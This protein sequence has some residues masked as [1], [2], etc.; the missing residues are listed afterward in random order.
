MAQING[1]FS[2]YSTSIFKPYIVWSITSQNQV[3]NTSTV[4]VNVYF[5]KY[6]ASY[7]AFNTGGFSM[8]ININ[9]STTSYTETFDL[10]SGSVPEIELI[11]TRTSTIT[12]NSDGT[13]SI[14][15][16][17]SGDTESIGT[18]NFGA[19][20][21]LT[22]IP[23]EATITNSPDFT[24]G[25][26]IPLT[27]SNPG[28]FYLKA[29]LYVNNTLISTDSIGQVT[30][31]TITPDSGEISAM[32]AQIT[33]ATSMSTNTFI[34]IQTFSDSG[35]T[36]QVGSNKDKAVTASINTT[37][38]VPTFTD[39]SVA[40][41]DKNVVVTDSYGNT[42]IT[43]S[44]STLLGSNTK[45]IK[46]YSKLRAT[47]SVAN[48]AVAQNSATM[49]KYKFISALQSKEENYSGVADVTLDIDNALEDDVSVQA[50]DSRGLSTT[51]NKTVTYMALYEELAL[52]NVALARTNSIED[53]TTLSFAGL[54]WKEYF[55]GG[56]AGVLNAV[57]CHYRYKETGHAWGALDGT[58]TVT[59]ASPGVFTKTAHGFA[60][61]DQ[62][63]LTT[64][65]ALPTGLT[66]N[67]YYYVIANT[68]DTFWLATSYAN[69]LASTKINTSGSQSGT[70]T[71][72][73]DSMWTSI[74]PTVD[75]SGNITYSAAVN[76][77]LGASGFNVN[78]SFDVEVRG[79]D[80]LSYVIATGVIDKGTPLIHKHADG[81][82]IKALFDTGVN[83]ALQVTGGIAIDGV[84]ITSTP[85]ELNLLDGMTAAKLSGRLKT[86]TVLTSGTAATYN[87][88]TGVTRI[89][90]EM[91]GG[92]GGGGGVS[93]AASQGA[94]GGGGGGGGYVLKFIDNV[95]ASYTYTVGAK[96]TGASSGNN[97]GNSGTASTF[98][99]GGSLN[100]SAG[101]G[102]GGSG[103]ASSATVP[104]YGGAGGA[105]GTSSGGDVNIA[106]RQGDRGLVL[107]LS[108]AE[109]HFGGKGADSIFGAG[110]WHGGGTNVGV[111]AANGY[112]AGGSGGSSR[113]SSSTGGG[114]GTD[115]IIIIYEFYGE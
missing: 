100:L 76:G 55:G 73:R 26:N 14:Y 105:G 51:V 53:E 57:V 115:G 23:R 47:V 7:N 88:P 45:M 25:D 70:H 31:Y 64:T 93:G 91:V 96:G 106:G 38:N 17:T 94:S 34:R 68:A 52:Y 60:T 71:V 98:S 4:E 109:Q 58:F 103:Q 9:G 102:T 81:V 82:S 39:Y 75:G 59:I 29:L 5:G 48:K 89:A 24:V 111:A 72:H 32:Y 85:A 107:A 36:T 101:G 78:K 12:H 21:A 104:R 15:I 114:N 69:A 80:K 43:S 63:Y 90:V 27:I 3:N 97:T 79:Y 74:T 67:T 22:A 37:T 99:N 84:S 86:I 20:V 13:K 16:G 42:L 108:S 50:I 6:N 8:S 41:V 110:A 28:N 83:S 10:R 30:S 113:S 56:V 40:N 1:S 11:R 49:S 62:V 92:G 35:Y 66:A 2:S 95:A 46:G 65:G 18:F 54:L 112:G 87:R 19:T 77:D 33:S 44:T 61:G